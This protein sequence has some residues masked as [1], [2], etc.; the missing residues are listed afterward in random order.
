M[1]SKLLT[2]CA[3]GGSVTQTGRGDHWNLAQRTME[4]KVLNVVE[5]L[6]FHRLISQT[7]K[8]T[9]RWATFFPMSG[10]V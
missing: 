6:K 5:T 2:H 3:G 10:F 8:R 9:T 4:R 1:R 7:T